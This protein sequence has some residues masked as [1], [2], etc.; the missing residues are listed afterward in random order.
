MTSVSYPLRRSAGTSLRHGACTLPGMAK[1][2]LPPWRRECAD[3]RAAVRGAGLVKRGG[4]L[5]LPSY[6]NVAFEALVAKLRQTPAVRVLRDAMPGTAWRIPLASA[7]FYTRGRQ[8]WQYIDRH[9]AHVAWVA[10]IDIA[11]GLRATP[12]SVVLDVLGPDAEGLVAAAGAGAGAGELARATW[13]AVG[14]RVVEGVRR[15]TK[16]LPAGEIARYSPDYR[17]ALA[18]ALSTG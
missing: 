13:E 17:A 9:V 2:I 6:S 4:V 8:G 7:A 5:V 16:I 12:L 10:D 15:R 11:S 3:L 18:E 1:L 14:Q